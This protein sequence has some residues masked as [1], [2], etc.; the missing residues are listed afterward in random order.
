[1]A[2]IYQNPFC[3]HCNYGV[4][5]IHQDVCLNALTVNRE[6]VYDIVFSAVLDTSRTLSSLEKQH[7]VTGKCAITEIYSNID[8]RIV[9]LYTTCLSFALIEFFTI[10]EICFPSDTVHDL[11]DILIRNN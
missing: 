9:I 5:W 11:Q 3:Y 1:M 4:G 10:E 2:A 7:E 8:V 6:I